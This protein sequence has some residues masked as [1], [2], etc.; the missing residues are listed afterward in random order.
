VLASIAV[1]AL[2]ADLEVHSRAGGAAMMALVV[3]LCAALARVGWVARRGGRMLLAAAAASSTF[4][5]LRVSPWLVLV[6][7]VTIAFLLTLACSAERNGRFGDTRFATLVLRLGSTVG[8]MFVAVEPLGRAIA[9]TVPRSD[10]STRNVARSVLRGL[11]VAVPVVVVIGLMLASADAVF[12]S[13]FTIDLHL[14]RWVGHVVVVAVAAVVATG[15]FVQASRPP[16]SHPTR[17][18]SVGAV[19]ATVVMV[20]LTAV[21][22]VFAWTQLL[23]AR[24]G[25]DYVAAMTGLTYAEYARSGFFQLL[26]VA[27]AT[28]LV[29]L[30][31]RSVVVP[32]GRGA[33]RCIA[34]TGTVA[35][36]LTLVVVHA[37]IVRLDLYESAFGLTLLR[38]SASAVAWW[39]GAVF[40]VIAGW[41]ALGIRSRRDWLPTALGLV[42]LAMVVGLNV[43][44]PEATV[45]RHNLDRV[46][47][48]QEFDVDYALRLSD[49]SV[50][51]LVDSIDLLPMEQ[52]EWLQRDLCRAGS[53]GPTRWTFAESA[54]ASSLRQLCS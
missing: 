34:V 31:V 22:A 10:G 8:A 45:M 12:A 44:D 2:L 14:D 41:F 49:D 18:F 37:A 48:G 38:Y 15:W 26:W 6:N 25:P 50:P 32:A 52:A 27:G 35:A 46:R 28:A 36:L 24:R 40:V 21:Y 5:V 11:L 7:L 23:V 39:L 30:V 17:S 1:V 54:A 47:D 51:T 4:L 20:G 33:A 29:L 9:S 43:A 16:V 3:V 19:E 53:S 13:V 42:S